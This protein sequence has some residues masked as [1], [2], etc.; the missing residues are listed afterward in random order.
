MPTR[1]KVLRNGTIGGEEPLRLSW[2][3]EPLHAPLPLPGGLVS[4]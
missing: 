1:A 3:L 2:G 4:V